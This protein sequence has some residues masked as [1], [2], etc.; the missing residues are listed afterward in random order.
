MRKINLNR[1][2]S[3]HECVFSLLM[4]SVVIDEA[5]KEKDEKSNFGILD[6]E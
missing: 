1:N 5:I 3:Q 4:F 6:D 2:R